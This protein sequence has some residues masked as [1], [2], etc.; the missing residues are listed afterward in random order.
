MK[1]TSL[2]VLVVIGMLTA[3]VPMAGQA[4]L[5]GRVVDSTGNPLRG[6]EVVI[7]ASAPLATSGAN[8]TF[9]TAN[10][11][12]GEQTVVFRAVGFKPQELHRTFAA[13]DSIAVE[14]VMP[15]GVQVLPVLTTR[16]ERRAVSPRMAGYFERKERGLGT[17]IDDSLLRSREHSP[18]S[19][20]LR[21]VPG[22]TLTYLPNGGG[23]AVQ[24]SRAGTTSTCPIGAQ[25]KKDTRCF[26]QVY[27]DGMRIYAPG[28]QPA[29]SRG[30]SIDEFKVVHLQAIEVYKGPAA[31]PAQFNMTGSS[32]GTVVLWTRDH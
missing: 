29:D 27:L 31:T 14:V 23:M 15:V 11:P 2:M 17:F 32:C 12:S 19:D 4:I 22:L 5:T 16:A 21:R 9:R 26:A 1:T 13:G 7:G 10:V 30:F 8:G 3:P 25:C 6:V 24:M 18:V 28:Q 20:V